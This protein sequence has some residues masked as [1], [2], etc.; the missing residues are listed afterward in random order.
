MNSFTVIELN[1]ER[2]YLQIHHHTERLNNGIHLQTSTGT[3]EFMFL[4][5]EW[6]VRAGLSVATGPTITAIPPSPMLPHVRTSRT[7]R[8]ESLLAT[9]FYQF[10]ATQFYQFLATQF[11]QSLRRQGFYSV[12]CVGVRRRKE[13]I[14]TIKCS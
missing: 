2:L 10:L 11:H 4:P 3:T 13:I 12:A 1:K 8:T 5:E 9:Q 7:L 14:V 6:W